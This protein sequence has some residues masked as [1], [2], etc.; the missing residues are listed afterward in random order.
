MGSGLI[1]MSSQQYLK[2]FPL[3]HPS[4]IFKGSFYSKKTM[5]QD[6]I[7]NVSAAEFS[8]K[9]GQW[10]SSEPRGDGGRIGAS[11]GILFHTYGYYQ[12]PKQFWNEDFDLFSL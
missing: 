7:H 6:N 5:T 9:Y 2:F 12:Q 1:F 10:K 3:F 4:M 11:R 8:T